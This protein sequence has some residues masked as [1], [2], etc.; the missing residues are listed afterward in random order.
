[1]SLAAPEFQASQCPSKGRVPQQ[2]HPRKLPPTL[3][4][5]RWQT[6]SKPK[7]HSSLSL[8]DLVFRFNCRTVSCI[9]NL[10]V[11]RDQKYRLIQLRRFGKHRGSYIEEKKSKR[12]ILN[13][14]QKIEKFPLIFIFSDVL[15]ELIS[16]S[17]LNDL[18]VC[19]N[20]FIC[21]QLINLF[22]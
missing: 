5:L 12:Q 2:G 1:M 21:G 19:N 8:G 22:L 16:V 10:N 3:F 6:Q 17:H 4:L 18:V 20:V 11:Q 14:P 9:Q 15:F 13:L 7:V